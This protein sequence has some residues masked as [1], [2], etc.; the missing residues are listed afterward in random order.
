MT[1]KL[2][3]IKNWMFL[4]RK[5][6]KKKSSTRMDIEGIIQEIIGIQIE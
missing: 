5:K 1:Q 2:H 4:V 6:A 3:F